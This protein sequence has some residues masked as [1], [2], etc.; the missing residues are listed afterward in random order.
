VLDIVSRFQVRCERG[1]LTT[2]RM[3]LTIRRGGKEKETDRDDDGSSKELVR[4]RLQRAHRSPSSLL[5]LENLPTFKSTDVTLTALP[6][7]LPIA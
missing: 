2:L 1:Y 5:T 7:Y 6:A 4:C 3:R